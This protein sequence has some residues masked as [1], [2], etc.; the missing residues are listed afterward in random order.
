[1]RPKALRMTTLSQP[2]T[3]DK[4]SRMMRLVMSRASMGSPGSSGVERPR[5]MICAERFGSKRV[6]SAHQMRSQSSASMSW[7]TTITPL[8]P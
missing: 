5:S 8:S 7:S 6:D 4:A 2:D 3:G 1:M